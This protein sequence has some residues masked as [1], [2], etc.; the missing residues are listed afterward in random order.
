MLDQIPL[1]LL[2]SFSRFIGV[3][4]HAK[5]QNDASLP[6]GDI[7]NQKICNFDIFD[8]FG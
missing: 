3:Y 5:N 6:S 4:L 8:N 2:I 1:K 7:A